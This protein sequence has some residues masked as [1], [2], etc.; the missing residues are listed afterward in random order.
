[1]FLF[2][3]TSLKT[4]KG[5]IHEKANLHNRKDETDL[6]GIDFLLHGSREHLGSSRQ[7]PVYL[8]LQQHKNTRGKE[9]LSGNKNVAFMFGQKA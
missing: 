3:L 2:F 8:L 1:M 5:L 4:R 9:G 6:G 7:T